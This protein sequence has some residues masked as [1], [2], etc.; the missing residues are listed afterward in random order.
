[1]YTFTG[2]WIDHANAILAKSNKL[3]E[4]TFQH[5]HS[6]VEPHHKSGADDSEHLTMVNQERGNERR[7]NQMKAF[8]KDIIKAMEGSDEI[9]IFGPSTAKY[10]LKNLLEDHKVLFAK[11]K[12]LETADD[13]SE[14]MIKDF[15]MEYF[16]LP[17]D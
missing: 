11:L 2:V 3:G 9:V 6:H 17:Q 10:E 5:F 8:C 1:M 7:H 12:G 16:K 4:M 15:M 14:A 13:M